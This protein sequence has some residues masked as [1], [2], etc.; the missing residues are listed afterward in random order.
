MLLGE[1]RFKKHT[2]KKDWGGGGG[3]EFSGGNF[4]HKIAFSRKK[5]NNSNIHN[6]LDRNLHVVNKI[7]QLSSVFSFCLW[8]ELR[9]DF[10]TW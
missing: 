1:Q 2:K 9:D 8:H 3:E 5:Q 4:F 10:A 7:Q 6:D